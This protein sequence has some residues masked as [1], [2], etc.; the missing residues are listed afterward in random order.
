MSKLKRK[1]TLNL[2][3]YLENQTRGEDD[4]EKINKY[5]K[6]IADLKKTINL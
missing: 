2:I 3:S 6:E 5:R 4:R 1:E